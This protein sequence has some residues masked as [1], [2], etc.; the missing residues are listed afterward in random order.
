MTN[1]NVVFTEGEKELFIED[2][3]TVCAEYFE[4]GEKY[5]VDV[6]TTANGLSVCIVFDAARVRSFRKA[7]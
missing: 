3:K 6:A 4:G 2:L 5:A 1:E 7:N